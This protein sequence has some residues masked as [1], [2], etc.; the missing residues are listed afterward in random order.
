MRLRSLPNESTHI[1]VE[2]LDIA[3]KMTQVIH[4]WIAVNL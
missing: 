4:G 2:L 3:I 1:C